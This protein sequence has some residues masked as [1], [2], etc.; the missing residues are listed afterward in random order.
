MS[1]PTNSQIRYAANKFYARSLLD[2]LTLEPGNE[3]NTNT[4]GKLSGSAFVE[5]LF[6]N[7]VYCLTSSPA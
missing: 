7:E 3:N 6:G 1:A 5:H 4:L 2:L